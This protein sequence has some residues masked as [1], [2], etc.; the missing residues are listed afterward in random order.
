MVEPKEFLEAGQAFH[1]HKCPAMPMGLR[2][3][4][5]AM[6]KLGVE[7]AQDGQLLALVELGEDH[8][9]TCF[10]D[11]IQMITGCTFGKGNI[12]KLHHGKWGVTLIDTKTGRAVR[13]TPKAEAM[14]ANKKSD[15]FAKYRE[16]GIPASKVPAEVVDPL[17]KKVMS[18]PE[19]QL[20]DVGEIMEYAVPKKVDSFAGFVCDNCGGL[21]EYLGLPFP[22]SY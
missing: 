2:V 9:A 19:N 22:G 12:R 21:F 16:K 13:V 1:G 8:C 10:G 18:A 17:V 14:L 7:R 3:G 11:G 4:A 20:L 6:N 15:F 5:A